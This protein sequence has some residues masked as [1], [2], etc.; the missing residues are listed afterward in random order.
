ML[1]L[2]SMHIMALL[3]WSAALFYLAALLTSVEGRSVV[4]P[5]IPSQ[6]DSMARFVYTQIAS[7]AALAAVIAGSAV[8]WI[9]GTLTF[10]LIAKLTLVTLLVVLHASMGLLV[11]RVE[12]GQLVGLQ[13]I[14]RLVALVLTLLLGLILW[15]VLTKPDVPAGWPWT[16]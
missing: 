2:L 15:L 7:P 4:L 1:W 13:R 14:G 10:W 11:L 9:N 5:H 6:H 12:R 8:F 3:I 16:L